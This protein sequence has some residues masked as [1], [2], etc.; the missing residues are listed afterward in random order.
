MD[1]VP[2]YACT[3]TGCGIMNSLVCGFAPSPVGTVPSEVHTNNR[4]LLDTVDYSIHF[5]QFI[6]ISMK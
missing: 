6:E 1:S 4:V 2:S 3:G 5:V